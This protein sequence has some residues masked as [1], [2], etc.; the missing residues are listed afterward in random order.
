MDNSA[1]LIKFIS[2]KILF[3]ESKIHEL[4][5]YYYVNKVNSILSL[6]RYIDCMKNFGEITNLLR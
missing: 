6:G 4:S 2:S 5:K 3:F 1:T